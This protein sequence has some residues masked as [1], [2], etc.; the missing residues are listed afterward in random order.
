[1][2]QGLNDGLSVPLRGQILSC[3]F[4]NYNNSS[5]ILCV[6]AVSNE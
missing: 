4:E 1:M 3:I 5:L 2:G 6:I